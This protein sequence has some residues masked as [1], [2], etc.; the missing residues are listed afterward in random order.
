MQYKLR[1][2]LIEKVSSQTER[3]IYL[4]KKYARTL[5]KSCHLPFVMR[6][7]LSS[8]KLRAKLRNLYENRKLLTNFWPKTAVSRFFS[9]N[10]RFLFAATN[11]IF[12]FPNERNI[13]ES[14]FTVGC[15]NFENLSQIMRYA[16]SRYDHLVLQLC[17]ANNCMC[18]CCGF[19][20]CEVELCK[21]DEKSLRARS[22]HCNS[23]ISTNYWCFDYSVSDSIT[24]TTVF[25]A[26][27][28]AV[29]RDFY[30]VWQLT[31]EIL[32]K[33]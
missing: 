6:Y 3:V 5:Y 29:I 12:F 11:I 23:W 25:R 2:H 15:S 32:I 21:H 4:R 9:D 13:P 30:L 10:G 18:N 17:I 28:G 33:N 14:G 1:K 20:F 31:Y 8:I 22:L 24:N 27:T 16:S 7:R 26:P 19:F